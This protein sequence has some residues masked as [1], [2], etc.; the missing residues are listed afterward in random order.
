NKPFDIKNL[1]DKAVLVQ[2][3]ATW[4]EPCKVDMLLLKELK[5]KYKDFEVVGI[6]LDSSRSDM[7]TFLKETKTPWPQLFEEGGQ[8]SR[9]ANELGIQILPTM[10]L[11]DK[12]GKVV[13]RN[14]HSA[15]L[16]GE[17]KKLISAK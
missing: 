15:E 9:Y 2:Y 3:W 1:K 12:Q 11:L 17:L 16:D 5:S 14:I 10:I 6:C 7:M 13:N 4:S 8:D